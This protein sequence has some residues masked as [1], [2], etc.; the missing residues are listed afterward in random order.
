M[1]IP[2]RTMSGVCLV[3]FILLAHVH[4][5]AISVEHDL[6]INQQQINITGKLARSMTIN[7]VMTLFHHK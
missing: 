4:A 6:A 3:L 1:I 5:Q 2:V 7:G